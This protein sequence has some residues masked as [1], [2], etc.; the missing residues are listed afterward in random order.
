MNP[1]NGLVFKGVEKFRR[2]AELGRQIKAA[3]KPAL[4]KWVWGASEMLHVWQSDLRRALVLLNSSW[5]RADCVVL[6][7]PHDF[8]FGRLEC[9][10]ERRKRPLS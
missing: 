1:F 5:R 8:V 7:V 4:G 6:P 10:Q 2:G 9:K 3:E